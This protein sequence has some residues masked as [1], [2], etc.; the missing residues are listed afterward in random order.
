MDLKNPFRCFDLGYLLRSLAIGIL[1]IG[2]AIAD[3]PFPDR[4]AAR[5]GIAVAQSIAFGYLVV[6]TLWHISRLDELY[7]RIHLIAIAIAFGFVGLVVTAA[8]FLSHAGL[9]VPPLGVWL[10]FV[11]IVVWAVGASLIARRYR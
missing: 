5:I 11:M 1:L 3:K 6:T 4:S 8:E 7:Q 9:P 10:W 2:L